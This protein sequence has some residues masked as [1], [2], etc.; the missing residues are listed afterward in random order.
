MS[1]IKNFFMVALMMVSSV[2]FVKIYAKGSEGSIKCQ[3]LVLTGS[4]N[5]IALSNTNGVKAI[6]NALDIPQDAF[7]FSDFIIASQE[8]GAVFGSQGFNTYYHHL[9]KKN[10]KVKRK[11]SKLSKANFQ[12]YAGSREDLIRD[13]I[14]VEIP[15]RHVSNLE[16]YKIQF[17]RFCSIEITPD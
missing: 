12:S 3:Q 14:A 15:S 7:R 4:G 2:H 17:E 10:T 5:R 6:E 13:E 1:W 16:G 11:S 8:T 9:A